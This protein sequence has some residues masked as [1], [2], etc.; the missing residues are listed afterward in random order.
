MGHGLRDV[1]RALR[2]RPVGL[3]AHRLGW[4]LQPARCGRVV[5]PLSFGGRVATGP[6]GPR[7]D[8]RVVARRVVVGAR[9]LESSIGLL[10]EIPLSIMKHDFSTK[11]KKHEFSTQ[12]H[13]C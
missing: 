5:R 11:T 1:D 8:P 2:P 6:E 7:G 4:T 3:T 10:H 12:I 9:A 13:D